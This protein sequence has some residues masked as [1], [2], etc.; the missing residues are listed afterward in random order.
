MV[1]LDWQSLYKCAVLEQDHS[2][3]AP[4]AAAAQAAIINRLAEL[5]SQPRNGEHEALREAFRNLSE[6]LARDK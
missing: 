2:K 4:K 1:P 5:S 3:F 6:L